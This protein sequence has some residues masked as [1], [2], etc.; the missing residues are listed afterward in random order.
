[1][2]WVM[3]LVSTLRSST[4]TGI[5]ASIAFSTT[6]VRPANSLGEIEQHVDLLDDQVLAIGDL[7]LGLVLAVGDDELDLGMVLRLGLDVLVE[8]HAPGLERGALAEADFPFR[9]RLGRRPA[10]RQ[11]DRHR[12]AGH[13]RRQLQKFTTLHRDPPLQIAHLRRLAA[14]GFGRSRLG[15]G[16]RRSALNRHRATKLAEILLLHEHRADDDQPLHHEL[17]VGV[18][19]LKLKDVGEQA[20][21]QDADEGA[22]EAAAPA[23]QAGAADHHGGDGV[24]LEAGA[25]VRLALPVLRD[26]QDAG[27]SG[28]QAR[29]ADRP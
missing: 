19:V 15:A 29:R 28:Q 24:E 13:G 6:P 12:G 1:M 7:L 14:D 21:D 16:L 27:D 2:N 3:R 8:L 25:G 18:D 10:G 11:V 26:E 4:M 17:D 9:R 5:L 23:H 22:G 20:E